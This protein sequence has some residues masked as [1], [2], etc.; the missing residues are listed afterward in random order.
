[1]LTSSVG[2][3]PLDPLPSKTYKGALKFEVLCV[4]VKQIT[5]NWKSH[6]MLDRAMSRWR[7]HVKNQVSQSCAGGHFGKRHWRNLRNLLWFRS[8]AAKNRPGV[9]LPPPLVL[10]GLLIVKSNKLFKEERWYSSNAIIFRQWSHL[11]FSNEWSSTVGTWI[12]FWSS[13]P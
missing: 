13:L 4:S 12:A 6:E 7:H 10:W 11:C 3:S 8:Y 5:K 9:N 1:M 2:L